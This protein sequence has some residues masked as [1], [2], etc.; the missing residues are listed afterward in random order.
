MCSFLL[1]VHMTDEQIDIVAQ[2]RWTVKN[3]FSTYVWSKVDSCFCEALYVNL[4]DLQNDLH[5]SKAIAYFLLFVVLLL[6]Q[7]T[8]LSGPLTED[9]CSQLQYLKKRPQ[10]PFL[11]HLGYHQSNS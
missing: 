3:S 5:N 11:F 10:L 2:E 8:D 1:K 7:N 9:R 4:E 6:F